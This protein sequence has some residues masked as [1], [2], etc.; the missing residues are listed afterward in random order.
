MKH[1]MLKSVALAACFGVLASSAFG[2]VEEGIAAYTT[3]NYAKAI[4][5]FKLSAERGDAVSQYS[6]G[7][8]YDNGQ[9]VAKDTTEAGRWYR[10]AAEQG[11]AAAQYNLGLI[12]HT[13]KGAP[14]D[15][16]EA[17]KWFLSSAKQG[18]APAQYNLG[19]MYV[20]GKGVPQDYAKAAYWF[21]LAADQ[22]DASAQNN[23]GMLYEN[24][25]GV[26]KLK[27][28][29]YALFNVSATADPSDSNKA[30]K[31][32]T[33]LANSMSAQAVNEGQAL[34]RA[35]LQPNKFLITLNTYVRN[36]TFE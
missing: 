23:L 11:H 33:R 28:V 24:G 18:V 17:A 2:G 12:Y 19:V 27:V 22:G 26:K 36:Q 30:T 14:K 4:Y 13:G 5:E 21:I 8:M 25:Q 32:R 15:N 7:V 6:L 29:A 31:N 34:T 16:K 3:G 35:L 1:K 20:D 9:G 10:L